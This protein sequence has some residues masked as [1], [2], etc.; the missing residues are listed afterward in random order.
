M[1]AL[2]KT[3]WFLPLFSVALGLLFFA[4]QPV[5][6]ARCDRRPRLRCRD[7]L[8]QVEVLS[9]VS[10]VGSSSRRGGRTSRHVHCS[11]FLSS[12][13]RISL[14]PWRNRFPCTLS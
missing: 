2:H 11:A 9:S 8:P 3:K 7:R 6:P 10:T 4:G 1:T 14:V 13:N 5:R 12:R